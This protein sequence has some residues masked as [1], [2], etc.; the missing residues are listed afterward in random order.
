MESDA[1]ITVGRGTS[2]RRP[3]TIPQPSSGRSGWALLWIA[4]IVYGSLL[5]FD[6]HWT[7]PATALFFAFEGCTAF[8]SLEDVIVNLLV[9]VP[10]GL[11]IGSN[12]RRLRK[13][14]GRILAAGA[15][16]LVLSTMLE[17]VQT[18][19]PSRVASWADVV[20]NVV[21][22]AGGALVVP[23]MVRLLTAAR[24]RL[25]AALRIDPCA[26]AASIL[27]I[28]LFV[29]HL[30]PFDFVV[31]TDRLHEAFRKT[32]I[33][34]TAGSFPTETLAELESAAWFA[35]LAFLWTR[36]GTTNTVS[37]THVRA[38]AIV[39]VF[40]L[41]GL[42]ECLQLFT[43]SHVFEPA[44]IALRTVAAMIGAHLA[45]FRTRMHLI[46]SSRRRNA[47]APVQ[48]PSRFDAPLA[49]GAVTV[50]LLLL[51]TGGPHRASGTGGFPWPLLSLWRAPLSVAVPEALQ[52]VIV[53]AAPLA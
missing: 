8:S 46:G 36:A 5:P 26:A 10:I 45:G 31:G 47:R 7:R 2:H 20:L 22:A 21:G 42:I 27:T 25:I 12:T 4:L 51:W 1:H 16:A 37:K 30:L 35:L 53:C 33:V 34:T 24:S 44:S 41:A 17:S 11:W 23:H 49:A 50:S 48:D 13:P 15:F 28:G 39:Q 38:H 52:R 32:M 14:I 29:Y 43:R 19:L 40:V 6:F 9:Y 3:G 18:A